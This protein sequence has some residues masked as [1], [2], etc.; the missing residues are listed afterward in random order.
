MMPRR[1]RFARETRLL[2]V[3][4]VL[5]AGTLL[6]L[7]RFR[8]PD[9]PPPALPRE[10]PLQR[11]A[12]EALFD[13]LATT[14]ALARSRVAP[15]VSVLQLDAPVGTPSTG[16]GPHR[17]FTPALRFRDDLAV[18]AVGSA[19]QLRL[20]TGEGVSDAALV[21]ED[22]VRGFAVVRLREA[23]PL[24]GPPPL[25][26][27]PARTT[28]TGYAVAIDGAPGGPAARPVFVDRFDPLPGS[29][30]PGA[31][32]L[33]P[34][35]Q[36]G[37]P[38]TVVVDLDGRVVGMVVGR[39]DLALVPAFTLV[40][41]A[42]RLLTASASPP[43]TMGVELQDL[44]RALAS[45]TLAT[46]G[47]VVAFVDPTGPAAGVLRGGDVIEEMQGEAVA[48]AADVLQ[49]VRAAEPGS[50]VLLGVRRGGEVSVLQVTL[51]AAAPAGAAADEAPATRPPELGLTL[52]AEQGSGSRVRAV[53]PGT[54]AARAGLEPGDVIAWIGDDEQPAPSAVRR[55]YADAAPGASILVGVARA[56]T[57]RVFV[58]EKR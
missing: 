32:A 43:A 19:A 13:E 42:E 4:V 55:A 9:A 23:P 34:S 3:T 56:G 52:A 40:R 39:R 16:A 25:D 58:V 7:A 48:S 47:A 8:F 41:A 22:V 50:T 21:A 20:L 36:P 29:F 53:A 1:L 54:A 38:G 28:P 14:V 44:D 51:A 15:F 57:H 5:S 37:Q 2:L 18:A 12:A 26:P 46:G 10:Q 35:L 27:V 33:P 45:A 31:R 24:A 11:L 49:R 17:W 6:V 30:W